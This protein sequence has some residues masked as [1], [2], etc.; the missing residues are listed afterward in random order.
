MGIAKKITSITIP[1]GVTT[2]P[3][4]LFNTCESLKT[5]TIPETVTEIDQREHF[6]TA[7]A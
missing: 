3:E 7:V 6:R 2:L 4:Y 5:V 1:E